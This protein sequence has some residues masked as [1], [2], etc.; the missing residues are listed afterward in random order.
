MPK[1]NLLFP[2]NSFLIISLVL[3]AFSMLIQPTQ[4]NQCSN[5][6][7]SPFFTLPW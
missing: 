2:F 5:A 3:L 6:Q 4:A 1:T 7:C